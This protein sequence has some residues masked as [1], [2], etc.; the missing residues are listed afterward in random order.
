MNIALSV[1]LGV[2]G[3]FILMFLTTNL[4][5]LFVRGFFV[6]KETGKDTDLSDHMMTVF[7]A[8]F[9]AAFL[10]ALLNFINVW[11]LLAAALLGVGRLP[12]LIWEI[13]HKA[14]I[15][16]KNMPKTPLY[17]VISILDWL[18]LPIT[19]FAVYSLIG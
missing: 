10:F 11:A 16:A 17:V 14:K 4:V 3:Y 18:A 5:G 7:S 6:K 9:L 12:D 2:V 13:E 15:S 1:A 19:I 8:L